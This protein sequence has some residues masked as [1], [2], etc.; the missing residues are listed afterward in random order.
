MTHPNSKNSKRKKAQ[1]REGKKNQHSDFWV[2]EGRNKGHKKKA[3]KFYVNNLDNGAQY[4][5]F[6]A[7]GAA[8]FWNL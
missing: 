1:E 7:I 8:C 4:T 2:F 5:S 3:G 6:G